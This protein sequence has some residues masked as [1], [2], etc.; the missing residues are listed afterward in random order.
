MASDDRS[1]LP[2]RQ[3]QGGNVEAGVP[4]G[5]LADF[6]RTL[7][8]D[9]R[10]QAG[11]VMAFLEPAYVMDDC[12]GSCLD[13]AV[14][15][16]DRLVPTDGRVFEIVVF[17]LGGEDR[18]II[19]QRALIAFEGKHVIGLSVE[20]LV[21]DGTL[22]THRVDRHDRPLDGKHVQKLGNGGDL[23]GLL[24]HLDLSEHEALACGKGRDHVD[25]RLAGPLLERAAHR[26]AI[27]GDDVRR[28]ASQRGDPAGKA[29]LELLGVERGEDVA[30]VIVRWLL[31]ARPSTI[32]VRFSL[33][34]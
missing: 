27:D 3:R 24:G 6:A 20:D 18:D 31:R 30:E 29:L 32:S 23:V 16:I 26:L 1:Q 8:H 19:A 5:F 21:R 7:D 17:L 4:F 13:A 14:I 9:D 12:G 25:R 15:A 10:F 28:R 33:L 11:P 34:P 2:G 22:A